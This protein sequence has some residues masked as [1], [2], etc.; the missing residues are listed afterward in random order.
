M[1]SDG[2]QLTEIPTPGDTVT[3][4]RFSPDR[5][6]IVFL[7]QFIGTEGPDLWLM[8][9][10]GSGA[11]ELMAKTE[12][13]NN[14]IVSGGGPLGDM[15][16]PIFSPDGSKIM[17][18]GSKYCSGIGPCDYGIYTFSISDISTL[19]RIVEGSYT[20]RPNWSS[21]DI[22]LFD[23]SGGFWTVSPTGSGLSQLTSIGSHGRFSA[24]GTMIVFGHA[25]DS[26]VMNSDGSS[27]HVIGEPGDEYAPVWS[28]DGTEIGFN[29]S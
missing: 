11:Y 14:G 12:V 23:Q 15:H 2:S 10:D 8:N 3:Q 16:G 28:P 13:D 4:A 20:R 1:Q 7:S 21:T 27:Q 18:H 26:W 19:N 22:V 9:A 29:M 25:T 5:S 17:L 24:D 6:K